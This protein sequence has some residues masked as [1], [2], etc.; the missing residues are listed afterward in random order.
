MVS[1]RAHETHTSGGNL[2]RSSAA[3]SVFLATA[4]APLDTFRSK[5]GF[6]GSP[7]SALLPALR[8][9][10]FVHAR[11][12]RVA[13]LERVYRRVSVSRLY[14]CAWAGLGEHGYLCCT[15]SCASRAPPTR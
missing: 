12:L 11:D 9:G 5:Q 1:F 10:R 8:G 13:E 15:G 14:E 7:R 4:S 2:T 3:T 6:E